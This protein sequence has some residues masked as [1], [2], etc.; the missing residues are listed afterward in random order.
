MAS[1]S[2]TEFSK[3]LLDAWNN[4]QLNAVLGDAEAANVVGKVFSQAG[5][6]ATDAERIA[7]WRRFMTEEEPPT[8]KTRVVE[9]DDFPPTQ[10]VEP[11]EEP[12]EE[13]VEDPVEEP[14]ARCEG[15]AP[16]LDP[17]GAAEATMQAP[18]P[19]H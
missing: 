17:V 1:S 14:T 19:H 2:S 5:T 18:P 13:P 9:P 3:D 10:V 7:V 15:D 8:K 16:M 6:G 12:A 11:I 4:L